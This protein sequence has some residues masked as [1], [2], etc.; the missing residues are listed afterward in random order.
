MLVGYNH[1]INHE[2]KT[3]HIQTEDSGTP[4]M[5]VTTLL[6]ISGTIIA[7]KKTAYAELAQKDGYEADLLDLMQSQH[8]ELLIKLRDGFYDDKIKPLKDAAKGEEDVTAG[9]AISILDVLNSL[10]GSILE[11]ISKPKTSDSPLTE[12]QDKGFDE[13]I[14]GYLKS[15]DKGSQEK[16]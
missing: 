10:E 4:T 16:P 1:N 2:G 9:D 13:V 3:Y 8:K 12:K 14:L 6:F 7:S 5:C 15:K 11:A